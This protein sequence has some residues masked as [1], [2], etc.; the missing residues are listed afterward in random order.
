MG[1]EKK[2]QH[3]V[4]RSYLERWT[5]PGKY[6][7]YAYNKQQK[8][9]YLASIN[10]IAS[11]RYFY[12]IDFTGVLSEDD[13]KKFGLS[14]CD[15]KH[16]DDEQFIENFFATQIENDFKIRLSQIIDRINKMNPWEIRNCYF[17]SETDKFHLSFHLAMQYIRV[18]SVRNAM[19]DSNDCLRQALKDMGAS[20]EMIDQYT[21]QESQLPYIHG[22]MIMDGKE[23][24]N[25]AQSFFSLT[26]FVHVNRTSQPFYTSDNPIGTE[27]HVHH[28]FIS[29]AGL[30]SQGVEAYFP[31]SPNLMLIMLDGEYHT[32]FQKHDRRVI[33]LDN[34]EVVKYYNSRCVLYSDNCIF[35]TVNDFS[36]IDEILTKNPDVLNQ[37]HTVMSWGGNTYT[38]RRNEKAERE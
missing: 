34:P 18:K 3:F 36:V 9:S 21:V 15:P 26:W 6:Q 31:L 14:E 27:A 22:K 4:P 12:D 29:M 11:E 28:P 1:K 19:M 10:D 24:E 35:S 25:L 20:P 23:I 2:K 38:P 7:V 8:K 33:E 37:P 13:L 16:M 30:Q 32:Q 17:L 5:I